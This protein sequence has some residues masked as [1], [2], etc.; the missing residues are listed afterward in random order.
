M[1]ID[2]GGNERGVRGVSN[3]LERPKTGIRAGPKIMGLLC[4]LG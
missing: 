3:N 2:V 4:S 1:K